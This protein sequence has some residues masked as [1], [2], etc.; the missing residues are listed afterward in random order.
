ML[1]AIVAVLLAT[2]ATEPTW[3]EHYERGV[4]LVAQGQAAAA[5]TEIQTAL[6]MHDREGLQVPTSPQQYIDY[7]PNLYLAIASQ[8]T[9]ELEAARK[10]L[11]RAEDSGLA[12][13]SEVGRPLLVAY[14]LMLRGD[15]TGKEGRPTYAVYASKPPVLTEA[16]FTMLRN[17]VLSKCDLP[18]DTKMS[19]APWYANYELG[20][21]LERRAQ[22]DDALRARARRRRVRHRSEQQHPVHRRPDGRVNRCDAGRATTEYGPKQSRAA[23]RPISSNVPNRR[24][25][26]AT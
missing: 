7:L 19:E 2:T 4:R 17:D 8:M 13:K 15:M 23:T 20:L 6:T 26:P 14:Q 10:Y 5:R 12:A 24:L 11:A 25:V 22:L 21:E 1:T 9:G 16:D 3:Y 18:P